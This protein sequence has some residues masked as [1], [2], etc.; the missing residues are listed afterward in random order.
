MI[1]F[2]YKERE[3]R[4][5][6][7]YNEAEE[8]RHNNWDGVKNEMTT[9]ADEMEDLKNKIFEAIGEANKDN[10]QD[11]VQVSCYFG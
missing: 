5:H 10:F 7:E 3:K 8:R 1:N 11:C 6:D 2:C 4:I 9:N